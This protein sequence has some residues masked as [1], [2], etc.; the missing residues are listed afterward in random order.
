MFLKALEDFSGSLVVEG[1]V[2]LNVN[3]HVIH[4]DLEPFFCN[5]VCT[6]VIHKHLECRGGIGESEEHNSWFVKS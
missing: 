2:I 4:V 6:Y 1:K 3:T 5:H